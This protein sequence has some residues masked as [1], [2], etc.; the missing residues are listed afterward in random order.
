MPKEIIIEEKQRSR[1]HKKI[2]DLVLVCLAF[3]RPFPWYRTKMERNCG[4]WI[5]KREDFTVQKNPV[6]KASKLFSSHFTWKS[7]WLVTLALG[8]MDCTVVNVL[9][10]KQVSDKTLVYSVVLDAR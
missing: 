1:S 6:L 5:K 8:K 10:P 7:I 2:F 4:V 9:D 3:G